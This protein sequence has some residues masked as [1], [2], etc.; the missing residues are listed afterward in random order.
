MGS[1]KGL[2]KEEE[3]TWAEIAAKK[4][5]A[6]HLPVAVSVNAQ[7]VGPY[8]QIF[9]ED[10]LI[11]DNPAFAD[12]AP[13]FGL[14]S[15]H[16][17]MPAEDLFVLACDI[18]DMRMHLMENLLQQYHRQSHQVYAYQTNGRPQP[19]AAIYTAGGLKKIHSLYT[20]GNLER[21]SMMH[22]LEIL[23]TSL[24]AV[25]VE[26]LAAFHNYNEPGER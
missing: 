22:V 4:F 1:D 26:D 14:L 2:L 6:L 13:L 12:K 18:K 21:Y 20:K 23:E 10:I 11:T 25:G 5:R 9:S 15:V 7:Q 19:L 24:T 16:L 3:E 17:Q 8:S